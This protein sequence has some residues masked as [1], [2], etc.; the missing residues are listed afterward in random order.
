MYKLQNKL[1]K[2]DILK[3]YTKGFTQPADFKIGIEYERLRS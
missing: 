2:E 1:E 3:L